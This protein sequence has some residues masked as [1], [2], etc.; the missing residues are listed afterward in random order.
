MSSVSVHMSGDYQ[1]RRR[2]G[3]N[4]TSVYSLHTV[5]T[6]CLCV[7]VCRFYCFAHIWACMFATGDSADAYLEHDSLFLAWQVA[8]DCKKQYKY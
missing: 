2:K 5:Y 6:V 1:R 8:C 4:D 3:G 7:C